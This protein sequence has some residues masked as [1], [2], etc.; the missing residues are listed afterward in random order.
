M[1][2]NCS[3]LGCLNRGSCYNI[4]QLFVLKV[5]NMHRAVEVFVCGHGTCFFNPG[6]RTSN[7]V[8][9]MAK[10]RDVFG[11]CRREKPGSTVDRC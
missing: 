8:S 1:A 7:G 11:F 3:R 4:V 6:E 9:Y 5:F 2:S 10:R